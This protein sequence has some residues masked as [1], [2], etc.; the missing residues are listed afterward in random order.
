MR[1]IEHVFLSILG[2]GSEGILAKTLKRTT[3]SR[4]IVAIKL[5]AVGV[6]VMNGQGGWRSLQKCR[7]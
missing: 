1:E 6:R 7:S 3:H 5:G 2:A 4:A